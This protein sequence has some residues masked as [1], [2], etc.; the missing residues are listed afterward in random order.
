MFPH[1][2]FIY[3]WRRDLLQQAIS[4]EIAFQTKIWKLKDDQSNRERNRLQ[5]KPLNIYRYKE[6]LQRY[7]QGWRKFF[8]KNSIEF[9]EIVY[10]EFVKSFE[11][12][13]LK[14][15]DFLDC[16]LKSGK[17]IEMPIKKQSNEVNQAWYRC[18]NYIPE[19]LLANYSKMRA[20]IRQLIRKES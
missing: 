4:T 1:T 11:A 9:H 12:F 14:V 2:H 7:N 8:A 3:I 15:L 16:K 17:M 6:G 13:I 19:G 10:E 18:Y 20:S 5:F